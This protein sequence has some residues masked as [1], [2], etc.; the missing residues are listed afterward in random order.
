[1]GLYVTFVF[2]NYLKMVK[3]KFLIVDIPFVYNAIIG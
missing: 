1:M 2:M 3:T